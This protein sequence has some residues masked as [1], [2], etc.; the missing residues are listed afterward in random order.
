MVKKKARVKFLMREQII[1]AKPGHVPDKLPANM[2]P[3][4]YLVK[5]LSL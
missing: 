5:L 1:S 4:V 2:K 3:F